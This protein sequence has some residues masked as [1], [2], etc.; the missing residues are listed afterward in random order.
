MVC[1]EPIKTIDHKLGLNCVD[2]VNGEECR[3]LFKRIWYDGT[4]SLVLCKPKTGRTH[5][6]RVHLQFLGHLITNDP[7]YSNPSVW[8]ENLGKDGVEYSEDEHQEGRVNVKDVI[9]LLGEAQK[10]ATR[11]EAVEDEARVK[12]ALTNVPI[13]FPRGM[14]LDPDQPFCPECGHAQ[15]T[16]P[17]LDQLQIY[18][19]AYRYSGPGWAFRTSVLPGWIHKLEGGR[20]LLSISEIIDKISASVI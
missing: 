11:V 2:H 1:N 6:I 20:S 3:T 14:S 9:K 10:A 16:D 8:G 15:F 13:G 12:D 4:H 5:Q 17:S 7:L 19:H 18:L